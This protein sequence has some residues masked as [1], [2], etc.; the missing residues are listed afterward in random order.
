LPYIHA[1][2]LIALPDLFGYIKQ[3]YAC[4]AVAV[5]IRGDILINISA[6][7]DGQQRRRGKNAEKG[8]YKDYVDEMGAFFHMKSLLFDL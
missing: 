3:G 5:H 6:Q 7:N 4:F 2:C 1:A 8:Q